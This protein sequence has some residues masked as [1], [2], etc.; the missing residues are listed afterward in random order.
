VQVYR[1]PQGS[2]CVV[3]ARS[4]YV[5]ASAGSGCVMAE[6]GRATGTLPYMAPELRMAVPLE[7]LTS[8]ANLT[9]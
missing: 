4:Y 7:C 8:N 9:S 1:K 5:N 6:T 3:V 2:E